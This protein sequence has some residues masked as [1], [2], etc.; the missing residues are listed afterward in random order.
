MTA[1]K[2]EELILR[3]WFA[4][5][6]L[7]GMCAQEGLHEMDYSTLAGWA[8]SQAEAMLKRRSERKEDK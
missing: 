2:D 6:A 8:Y 7:A 3:D 4:G 5:Q 1:P